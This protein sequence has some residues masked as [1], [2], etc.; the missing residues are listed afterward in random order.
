MSG[1]MSILSLK[2][3]DA[4][5]FLAHAGRVLFAFLVQGKVDY[6]GMGMAVFAVIYL[7]MP[8]QNI[9]DFFNEEKFMSEEKTYD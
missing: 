2:S 4:T 5:L 6:L 7:F 8:I 3:L 9:I 1:K